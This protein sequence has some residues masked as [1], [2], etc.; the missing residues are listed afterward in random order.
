MSGWL[1]KINQCG[2]FGEMNKKQC[3]QKHGVCTSAVLL[4]LLHHGVTER[5]DFHNLHATRPLPKVCMC[6]HACVNTCFIE[7]GGG[8]GTSKVLVV[9]PS[10]T[11]IGNRCY[12]SLLGYEHFG[13]VLFSSAAE[14]VSGA[15]PMPCCPSSVCPSVR[16]IVHQ[17][18]FKS[19]SLPQLSYDLSDIWPECAQWYCT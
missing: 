16:L 11:L 10:G 5:L 8:G 13:F 1:P 19:K 18:F 9:Y 7:A 3:L 15:Y 6:V 14:I 4:S 2:S 17:P 12:P